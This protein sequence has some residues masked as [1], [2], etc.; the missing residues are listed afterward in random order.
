M[1]LRRMLIGIEVKVYAAGSQGHAE[2]PVPHRLAAHHT[3]TGM[4][5]ARSDRMWDMLPYALTYL[6]RA[7][8]LCATPLLLLEPAA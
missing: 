4:H 7:R 5:C 1:D 6:C 8:V 3:T 2:L